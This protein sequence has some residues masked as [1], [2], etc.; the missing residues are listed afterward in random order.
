MYRKKNKVLSKNEQAMFHALRDNL[1]SEYHIC[2]NM[3]IADVLQPSEGNDFKRRLYAILP[4]HVD[5]VICDKY[6]VPKVAVEVNGYQH[7]NPV[8]IA[9][10]RLV[11]RMFS[12]ADLPIEFVEIGTS[13][14]QSVERI[15]AYL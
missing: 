12:D 3:R 1:G 11:K 7:R 2:P 8:R 13:F 6:F 5:F 4:K 10:D 15:K 9:R 14:A